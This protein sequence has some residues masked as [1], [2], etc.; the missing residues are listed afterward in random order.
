MTM[1]TIRK[2]P[3]ILEL[4]FYIAVLLNCAAPKL[5]FAEGI[6]HSKHNLSVTGSGEVKAAEETE[7]CIFCHAPHTT[8]AQ[9]PLWNRYDSGQSYTTYTSTTLRAITRQPSGSSKL[10]LSCHD[11]TVA[12]GM[13]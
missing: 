13:T 3:G 11:G 7:I 2:P 6:V 5:G 9:A 12:L 8:T 4:T 1:R 10:C